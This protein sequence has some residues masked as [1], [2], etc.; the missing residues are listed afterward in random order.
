MSDA[1][2][3]TSGRPKHLIAMRSDSTKLTTTFVSKI[4]ATPSPPSSIS[5]PSSK[6]PSPRASGLSHLGKGIIE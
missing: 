1:R 6:A 3:R 5:R 4:T 2:E